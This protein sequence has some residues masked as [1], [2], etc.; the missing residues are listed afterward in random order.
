MLENWEGAM[1]INLYLGCLSKTDINLKKRSKSCII[2]IIFIQIHSPKT[3]IH[4]E[5]EA[6]SYGS[7]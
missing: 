1:G 4:C 5:V 2:R 6:Q 7:I 3:Q